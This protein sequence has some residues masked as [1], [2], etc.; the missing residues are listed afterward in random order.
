MVRPRGKK[1]RFGFL[2]AL[3]SLLAFQMTYFSAAPPAP[4]AETWT[5]Y[6]EAGM[7]A[8]V[9]YHFSAR[10]ELD[11][12]QSNEVWRIYRVMGDGSP[13]FSLTAKVLEGGTPPGGE[14]SQ[15]AQLNLSSTLPNGNTHDIWISPIY[16]GQSGTLSGGLPMGFYYDQ[17][18]DLAPH[19]GFMWFAAQYYLDPA[20]GAT[21]ECNRDRAGGPCENPGTPFTWP[22]QGAG[23]SASGSSGQ[24]SACSD[25]R[26]GCAAQGLPVWYVNLELLNLVIQDTD[27]RYDSFGRTV[28]MQR[29]WNLPVPNQ[30]GMFG[31][32][33]SF[34]YESSAVS[35]NLAQG[36]AG[37]DPMGLVFLNLGTGR[38]F[39]YTASVYEGVGTGQ[40]TIRYVCRNTMD[41]PRPLIVTGY[42]DEATRAERF[43]VRDQD[44]KITYYYGQTALGDVNGGRAHLLTSIEDRDGNLI[45]LTHGAND[46]LERLTDASGRETEFAYDGNNHCTAMTTFDGKQAFY[47][48]DAAGNLVETVDL[49]GNASTYTYDA[50]GHVTELATNGN[51]TTFTWTDASGYWKVASATNSLGHMERYEEVNGGVRVIDPRGGVT[52][53]TVT[54]DGTGGYSR[55]VTDRLGTTTTIFYTNNYASPYNLPPGLP[56]LCRRSDLSVPLWTADY[57]PV[58]NLV[59]FTDA[60][61]AS[62]FFTYDDRRNVTGIT[63]AVN[64]AWRFAYDGR[65]RLLEAVSPTGGRLSLLW[66][67][68]GNLSQITR[69]SGATYLLGYDPHG[70]LA[71]I[72]NP[73]GQKTTVAYDA[74]GLNPASIV[75]PLG[76]TTALTFDA[77]R[78]L[79]QVTNPDGTSRHYGYDCCA[80]TS[81]QDENGQTTVVERDSLQRPLSVTDPL[82]NVRSFDYDG[83][84]N[85][86]AWTDPLG[87][88]STHTY[89]AANRWVGWTNPVGAIV[90][91]TYDTRGNLT[92]LTDPGSG[93][94]G[95]TYDNNDH[96]VSVTDPLAWTQ[97]LSWNLLGQFTLLTNARGR[98]VGFEYDEDGRLVARKHDGSPFAGYAYDNDGNL[99]TVVDATGTTT[100]VHNAQGRVIE[101]QYD[102]GRATLAYD[103][104][105]NLTSIT[106]PSGLRTDYTYDARNRVIAMSWG[107]HAITFGYDAVGNL[108]SEFR[109]NGVN[110]MYT[111]DANNRSTGIEHAR[112]AEVI[113]GFQYSRNPVGS[114]IEETN[115]LPLAP[116]FKEKTS[117]MEYN[118]ANQLVSMDGNPCTYDQDGNLADMGD[119]F[120]ATYDPEN[121]LTAVTQGGNQKIYSYDGH[122]NRRS[123]EDQAGISREYYDPFGRLLFETDASGSITAQYVYDGMRLVAM[124]KGLDA[125]FYHFEKTGNTIA[126]TDR[127]GAVANAYAYEPFGAIIASSGQVRNPFTFVGAFGV[128]DEGGG[129][130]LMRNRYYDAVTGRFL[131]KDPIGF[132]GGINL[133]AYVGN[134]PVDR[135]DPQGTAG[136]FDAINSLYQAKKIGESCPVFGPV[137]AAFASAQI[138]CDQEIPDSVKAEARKK[139]IQ[140]SEECSRNQL[141][142]QW[143]FRLYVFLVLQALEQGSTLPSGLHGERRSDQWLPTGTWGGVS[144]VFEDLIR[145]P[146]GNTPNEKAADWI[147]RF[148]D[149]VVEGKGFER[150]LYEMGH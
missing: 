53:C 64:H 29:T 1:S 23:S 94:T 48:Y 8:T 69:P 41:N 119:T 83:N 87:Q 63:D 28:A 146:Y 22:P 15:F 113:A 66:D 19:D 101:V 45:T 54:P 57:D 112:G 34:A 16:D 109:S 124:M 78:H 145:M 139:A 52:T 76:R 74:T 105:G 133:Y 130:Y 92:S 75:D 6:G 122:G 132:M 128:R 24:R 10:A 137:A 30:D 126:L 59:T 27:F 135:M 21:L 43:I 120:S 140:S 65:D 138:G 58:G 99:T 117:V 103:A 3:G 148:L 47:H 115:R 55:S 102:I 20:C 98:A 118:D 12:N 61:G 125:Y 79:T 143:V 56:V 95:F 35:C 67:A 80:L 36:E 17:W 77:N 134:N 37:T 127:T 149:T 26:G 142:Q 84:G 14:F 73:L 68:L 33:W 51:G 72:T 50:K 85:V 150:I 96:P 97:A 49:A 9:E 38:R 2:L 90:Q 141:P 7:K 39:Q 110:S 32:G 31:R 131:Q 25:C 70:N 60:M 62:T 100:Y 144:D 44:A 106:Y 40:V 89:D 86:V 116:S 136:P 81:Y 107:D 108:L 104:A 93:T 111:Y 42:L 88:I 129:I 91:M 82:G 147:S 5:V 4:L 121:R 13:Q 114:I 18:V 123:V 46:R 71:A 11:V